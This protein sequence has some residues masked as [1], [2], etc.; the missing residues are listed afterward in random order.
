MTDARFDPDT[1]RRKRKARGLSLAALGRILGVS[2]QAVSQWEQGHTT[3]R[4]DL[5]MPLAAALHCNIDDL[6]T[7]AIGATA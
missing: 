5:L 2:H 3:P 1:L 7:P 4:I 6:F